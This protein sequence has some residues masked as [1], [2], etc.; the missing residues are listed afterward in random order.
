[1]KERLGHENVQTT[2]DLYGKLIPSLDAAL[3]DAL[4]ASIFGPQDKL[5]PLRTAANG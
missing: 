1:M 3:A 4:G 2:V 5:V